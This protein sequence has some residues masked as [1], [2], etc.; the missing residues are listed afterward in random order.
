M[1]I[2]KQKKTGRCPRGV[3]VKAMDCGICST[4]VPTPVTLSRSLSG[5]YPWERYEPHYPP[6][7]G[8]NS[9]TTVLL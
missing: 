8:V 6:S 4:R 7:Y 9:T 2:K 1:C 3:M 5:K